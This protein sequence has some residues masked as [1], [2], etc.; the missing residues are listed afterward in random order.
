MHNM[1]AAAGSHAQQ[2]IPY[3]LPLVSRLQLTQK[4]QAPDV[5]LPQPSHLQ[6][7]PHL[8]ACPPAPSAA[9]AQLCECCP[10]PS[11]S[12]TPHHAFY[13]PPPRTCSCAEQ[14]EAHK[15][16]G[17]AVDVK[18]VRNGLAKQQ[19]AHLAQPVLQHPVEGAG[20]RDGPGTQSHRVQQEGGSQ[21]AV[22]GRR[23]VRDGLRRQQWQQESQQHGK[24]TH[25]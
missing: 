22:G 4:R 10:H 17:L 9:P 23:K 15:V 21:H 8:V 7:R 19:R 20:C 13:S 2:Q 12:P 18:V 3:Q 16:P 25:Q 11:L 5:P 1:Q 14:Q 24:V 6:Q